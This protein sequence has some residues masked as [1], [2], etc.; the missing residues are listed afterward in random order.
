MLI[1]V[2]GYDH[3]VGVNFQ[4]L[5]MHMSRVRAEFDRGTSP[6]IALK[7]LRL[8]LERQEMADHVNLG[9]PGAANGAAI[10]ADIEPRT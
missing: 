4:H 2:Q 10:H 6:E 8:I 1:K 7:T 3:K 9:M 5:R